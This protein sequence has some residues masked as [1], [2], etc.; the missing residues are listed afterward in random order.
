[1]S[2]GRG[3]T[4]A[5]AARTHE[6]TVLALFDRLPELIVLIEADGRIRLANQRLLDTMGYT[7]EEVIGSNIFD[8]VHPDDLAYMAWSWENRQANPGE[9]GILIQARGRNA[10][11][12]WRAV[13]ILGLSLF[14]EDAVG[15]MVMSM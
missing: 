15:G 3:E 2:E 5:L 10:D 7:L 13:E 6:A 12:T 8:Y 1:M 9:T 11:D 4:G 14:D